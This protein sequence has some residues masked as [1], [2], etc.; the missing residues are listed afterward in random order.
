MDWFIERARALG[1]QHAAPPPIVLG[2]HLL[3]L[4]LEPGPRIGEILKQIY[5]R[6]L[7]GDVRTLEEGL[8]TAR[9]LLQGGT[10]YEGRS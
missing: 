1:V 2:R 6:Q 10:S 4:G 5:E 9:Q 8:A 3:D 7:D